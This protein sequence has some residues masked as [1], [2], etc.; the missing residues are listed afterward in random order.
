MVVK[1]F[2]R[3]IAA[4]MG[5]P[6]FDPSTEESPSALQRLSGHPQADIVFEASG[7]APA[8]RDAVHCCAVRGQISFVGIPKTPPEVDIL[9]IVYKEIHTASARVYR[10]R[11]Y[12]GA[13]ALLSRR[14]VEVEP[15]ITDRIALQEA[16]LAYRKMQAAETSAKVVVLP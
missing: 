2:R 11:D 12:L 7:C 10:F 4:Q 13:I 1:P 16:P 15:L 5:F 3:E 8:Y 9:K 14:A 6:T